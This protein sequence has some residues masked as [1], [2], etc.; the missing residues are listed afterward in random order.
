[1]QI[2]SRRMPLQYLIILLKAFLHKSL[3]Q[4][5]FP[6]LYVSLWNK[7]SFNGSLSVRLNHTHSVSEYLKEEWT[8]ALSLRAGGPE[9][10][11][12]SICLCSG[13]VVAQSQRLLLQLFWWTVP[14]QQAL[15]LALYTR[16]RGQQLITNP[17]C[18]P[19]KCIYSSVCISQFYAFGLA[20][21]GCLPLTRIM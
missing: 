3:Y 1:M 12:K 5:H 13:D 7:T 11:R 9:P 2:A 16:E 17:S 6:S 20:W 18:D 8:L 15:T 10:V 14:R 21:V 19:K 4:C